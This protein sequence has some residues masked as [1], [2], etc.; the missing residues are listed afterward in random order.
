MAASDYLFIAYSLLYQ[1]YFPLFLYK[2]VF[3]EDKMSNIRNYG[4]M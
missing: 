4:K 1:Q 3:L 2:Y